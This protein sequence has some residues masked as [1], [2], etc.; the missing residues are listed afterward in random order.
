MAHAWVNITY[1]DDEDFK[2]EVDKR[3]AATATTT[4]RPPAAVSGAERFR[5]P[6]IH[7]RGCC[8]EAAPPLCFR[9]EMVS[10][11]TVGCRFR[12]RPLAALAAGV[13]LAVSLVVPVAAQLPLPA[14]KD[15]GEAIYPAFE[16]WYPNPDG[17]YNL[18]LGYYNRNQKQTLDIP[19]GPNNRIEPGGPDMGQPTYFQSRRGWGVFTIK[20]PKD[21]G[22]EKRSPGRSSPTAR[23]RRCRS[24]LIKDYQIEPFKDTARATRR[25]C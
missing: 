8:R 14:I 9:T 1:M 5:E 16:G 19:V 24:G 22:S 4:T 2:V 15:S 18:L 6:A 13:A 12:V 23:R 10:D 20:V 17:S 3:K 11:E 25:R 21:F 7:I